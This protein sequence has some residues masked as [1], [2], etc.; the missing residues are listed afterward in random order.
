MVECAEL[1]NLIG[2]IFPTKFFG[3]TLS[4]LYINKILRECSR[5]PLYVIE[6]VVA[7]SQHKL[8]VSVFTVFTI[9]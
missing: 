6:S 7:F 3:C 2:V 8:H 4:Y 5:P 9:L 1:H